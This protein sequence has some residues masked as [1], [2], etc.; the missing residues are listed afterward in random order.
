MSAFASI[1]PRIIVG[2]LGILKAGGVY[3]PLDP[4][5]PAE[6]HAFILNEVAA[7]VILTIAEVATSLPSTTAKVI[8]LDRDWPLIED[9][10]TRTPCA[11]EAPSAVTS[12]DLAYLIFTSGS[13]LHPKAVAVPHCAVTRLVFDTNYVELGPT[14]RIAHLSN[15]CFDAATFEIWG[16]LLTGACIV[17]V[18]KAVFLDATRFAAELERHKVSTLF[19]TTALF[20]EL[21]AMNGRIFRVSSRCF[22]AVKPSIPSRSAESWKAAALPAGCFMF[23]VPPSAL[24]L[25]PSIR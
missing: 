1:V 13:T 10:G 22:L 18:P 23:T 5:Y 11:S 9:D 14:D 21:A 2:M 12:R 7:P 15:L 25:P 24:P 8:C 4:T 6:R 19:V 17:L 3:V 16:A 20:N